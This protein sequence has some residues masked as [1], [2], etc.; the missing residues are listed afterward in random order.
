MYRSAHRPYRSQGYSPFQTFKDRRL[1][2]IKKIVEGKVRYPE[3]FSASFRK[4]LGDLLR[5]NPG[6]R[7]RR[8]A[9]ILR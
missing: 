4:I 6:N 1:V 7:L 8:G 2:L 3:S 5:K 9:Q